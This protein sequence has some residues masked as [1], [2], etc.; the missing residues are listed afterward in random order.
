MFTIYSADVIGNP[1]NCSYPHKHVILDEASLKA[2]ICHDYVCAEYR[3]SYRNGDNFIGSDCLPVDCDNDHSENPADWM[4]PEDVMQA[5]PGVTFA[6]H[7]SRFHN[8][9]KNGKAA[10]PKFHVLFPIEHCTDASLYSDMKKLVNSIFP[11]FDT[12]ALDAAR[13]FFGTA[14]AE[15]ALYPGRMNLTEFLNED[16]FDEYLPQGDFDHSVIPEG[17]RNT[18]MSRFAGRVIKKYGD[19]EKAFQTFLEE[20]AKCVPPL[21]NAELS[22]IW[23]SAQRFYTK[24]S[25]Q[26]GYV[27]P[28][29]Y[30][31]PSCYKPED[32]SDVGQAEVLG[33]YFSSELRYSPATHF[34]R[35][36]DHY[37]QESEPGAQAVAHE[38]T[39][40][41]LKEAGNDLVEALTKMKNSGAQTILDSTSKSKA[42]QLMNEQQ[43][44]AYQDF[45][46]AKAYQ[47]FAIKRRDSKNITSTLR[48]SHPILEISPRDLDADP[49]ALCTP[50][51][52][53]DLR[54]GMAGAREH[55]PED[56]ITKITS[57][58]PSQ[59][60]QQ[61]WL[62]CLD[63]IFQGDQS[64]I[65]YVQMICG[66][67]AI[68]KVYVEALIIAYGDGRNGKSTFWNAVSRVLGLYSGNISADT[69]TVGCR[70]NIKPEM[71]EVK[72][73]RLLIA[74]EMQEGSRLNDSTV[75][76]LCST[77]DVFAEKKYKDPFSFKP[78]HTLVLYTNHLPRVSASDDGIWRRL[79][80]IP[81][82]AKITGKSDIKNYGEYLFDNAGESILAWVIE[83][84]KKVIDLDYK[85]TVPAIVQKAIDDYRSQNDWFGNFLDERCEIGAGFRESSSALYQAYRNH[86]ID[87]N[88]YIRN[89]ADFYN[90]L[91]NAG[92]ERVLL[93]RKR[94]FAGLKL[95]TDDGD[96]EDFLH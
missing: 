30:N 94:Y 33:K 77:D 90:A 63:L 24:L 71:A 62:D 44:E 79:I 18:T 4:T 85:I 95:K 48:E 67:A 12:Q 49:F 60:G 59:K 13:F 78:C 8:R 10:R 57:V 70:R 35:Y 23:H 52:T 5:F 45:L 16:L 68:G 1:G 80:V 76:Q 31:D 17:S 65:E 40:R 50:E 28:E 37:W 86:C 92:Y 19:T 2:A 55:S 74:A 88:E 39:R 46:A 42:E 11:Y 81:F 7:F 6:I 75:K 89:T 82:N 15:V 54:K 29:V 14:A 91:E 53:Y 25:Q 56:F 41:Q 93:N 58:S 9:E 21:D 69:L 22:T 38:L 83:G 26:D 36:S 84:A 51:A 47:A 73:K 72:G 87:T 61:I 27:A 20:A 96:F 3:N 34:I 32:Y 66:L 64:L 43:L